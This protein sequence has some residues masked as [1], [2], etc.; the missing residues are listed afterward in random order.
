MYA[1]VSG[2]SVLTV[3]Q[4]TALRIFSPPRWSI[5]PAVQCNAMASRYFENTLAEAADLKDA[6]LTR[7]E[8]LFRQLEHAVRGARSHDL[9][10]YT[11][12]TTTYLKPLH[13]IN[14]GHIVPMTC[15]TCRRIW[16]CVR[17]VTRG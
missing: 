6:S 3:Y 10:V 4:R 12:H 13:I 7:H 16:N 1:H 17:F 15:C 11:G 5:K 8:E 14:L 2:R 9:A